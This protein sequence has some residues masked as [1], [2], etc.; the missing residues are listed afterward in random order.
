MRGAI[1]KVA[2]E[3]LKLLVVG[4]MAGGVYLSVRS[5]GMNLPLPPVAGL[6][7]TARTLVVHAAPVAVERRRPDHPKPRRHAPHRSLAFGLA[8]L[9]TAPVRSAAAPVSE[10]SPVTSPQRPSF[11]G[12]KRTPSRSRA[13]PS[14]KPEPPAKPKP[15]PE[16][17]PKP[18][19][20]PRP[21][22]RP[23]PKPTPTPV[24][25]PTDPQPP[26]EPQAPRQPPPPA[27][28]PPSEPPVEAPRVADPAS[29]RLP[30]GD[31]PTDPLPV[32]KH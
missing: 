3:A 32:L 12:A 29:S 15:T 5:T 6:G 26:S 8:A 9:P 11:G 1:R 2:I 17:A 30:T 20:K 10:P 25:P 31:L 4:A 24:P 19:P 22:P 23:A 28:P 18:A 16:P 13:A 7:T 21:T 27:P 14:P